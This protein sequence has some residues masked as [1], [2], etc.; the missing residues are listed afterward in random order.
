MILCI[1]C[2]GYNRG[3]G[4]RFGT[5]PHAHTTH[6]HVC[7]SVQR[8]ISA[9]ATHTHTSTT[10]RK[11]IF[12]RHSAT[13]IALAIVDHRRHGEIGATGQSVATRPPKDGPCAPTRLVR[14]L[15]CADRGLWVREE[16]CKRVGRAWQGPINGASNMGWIDRGDIGSAEANGRGRRRAT[17]RS[18][19]TRAEHA[20]AR[21]IAAHRTPRRK[22]VR[23]SNLR[24]AC[25]GMR[26]VS[27]K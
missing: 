23:S 11:S 17:A 15:A 3:H 25:M 6:T 10:P 4:D 13:T 18:K 14:V 19:R 7:A 26:N 27:A 22:K 12:A 5:V 24:G 20:P 21:L 8:C 2:K 1:P 9:H 16:A